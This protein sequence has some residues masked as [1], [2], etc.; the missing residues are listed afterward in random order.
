MDAAD[1]FQSLLRQ[2]QANELL[3]SQQALR[4]GQ[5]VQQQQRAG[6]YAGST[7]QAADLMAAKQREENV[8]EDVIEVRGLGPLSCCHFACLGDRKH[9]A[10]QQAWGMHGKLGRR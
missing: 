5:Q 1:L 6:P 8:E 9:A 2:H 4:Q 10:A 7:G 3:R